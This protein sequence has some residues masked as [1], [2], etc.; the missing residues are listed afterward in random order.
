MESEVK[1]NVFI[2]NINE[3]T[4]FIAIVLM[5]G[6]L[7]GTKIWTHNTLNKTVKIVISLTP[8][9]PFDFSFRSF[10]DG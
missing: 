1:E 4:K 9:N 10:F 6:W 8:Q 2:Q 5:L 3:L 7:S